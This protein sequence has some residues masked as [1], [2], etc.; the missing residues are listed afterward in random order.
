[1]N[2]VK[3]LLSEGNATFK[4]IPI[5]TSQNFINSSFFSFKLFHMHSHKLLAKH[6]DTTKPD[7]V[8]CRSYHATW[9]ALKVREK[10]KLKYKVIFDAR[11]IWPLEVTLKRKE[12]QESKNYKFLNGVEQYCLDNSDKVI[13]VSESMSLYFAKKTQTDIETIYLSADT[14]QLSTIERRVKRCKDKSIMYC[15]LGALSSNTWH[16]PKELSELFKRLKTLTP[17]CKL[18]IITTSPKSGFLTYF[19][20]FPEGDIVVRSSTNINELK[21]LLTECDY[22]LMSYFTPECELQKTLSSSVLA[23]K[24]AEYLAAGMP[25]LVNKYCGG[26]ALFLKDYR[27]GISYDPE[28]L[29][30]LTLKHIKELFDIQPSKVKEAAKAHLNY[31][32]NA[33]K[34]SDVYNELYKGM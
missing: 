14:S 19:N 31:K 25:M 29:Q 26:A 30:T 27:V 8:H 20:C 18:M 24:T 34:Y 13:A 17:D 9:A 16:K 6:F 22:G 7:I 33:S 32:A 21:G 5:I 4:R 15:Y 10:Y 1:M 23:V 12:S 28:N 3:K 2:G 11:G